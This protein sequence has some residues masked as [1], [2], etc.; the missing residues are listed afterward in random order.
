MDRSF[1]AASLFAGVPPDPQASPPV[2]ETLWR[3]KREGAVSMTRGSRRIG[4][5]YLPLSPG[6]FE[7]RALVV[8]HP[9]A[10]ATG[11]RLD[12]IIDLGRDPPEQLNVLTSDL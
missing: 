9:L 4:E 7:D 3:R 5:D 12:A 11:N 6:E 10:L 1:S 8:F 2:V